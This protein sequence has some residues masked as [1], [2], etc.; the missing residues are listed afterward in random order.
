MTCQI[1]SASILNYMSKWLAV[2][3]LTLSTDKTNVITFNLNHLQDDSF[4]I[5]YQEK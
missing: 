5:L 2:N 1:R 4:Q 3:G